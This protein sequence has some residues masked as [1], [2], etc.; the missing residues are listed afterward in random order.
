MKKFTVEKIAETRTLVTFRDVTSRS[1][2]ISVEFVE[3]AN[4]GAKNSLPNLWKKHGYTD[5][6][7]GTYWAVSVFAENVDTCVYRECYNPTVKFSEDGKRM[8]LDFDWVLEA[9]SE[10]RETLL[11]EIE[12]RAFG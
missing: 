8:V 10:N 6:T 4:S 11:R 9:T 1:E 12:K 7:L 3:C 5:K 2:R